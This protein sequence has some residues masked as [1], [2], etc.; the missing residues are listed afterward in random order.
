MIRILICCAG[1]FSSSA[2]A[3]NVKKQIEQNGLGQQVAI[4][5]SPLSGAPKVMQHFDVIVT[6]PHLRYQLKDFNEKAIKNQLPLYVLPP[7]MYGI[8]DVNE[9]YEDAL[10]IVENFKKNPVNPYFFPGEE[11]IMRVTPLVSNRKAKRRS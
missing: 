8:M 6:C 2:M 1:G 3:A 5:F 11:D 7:R 4:D 9:I 10:D